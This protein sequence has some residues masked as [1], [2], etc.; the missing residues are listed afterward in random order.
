[1]NPYLLECYAGHLGPGQ[2]RALRVRAL[3]RD[4][5]RPHGQVAGLLRA[6]FGAGLWDPSD[7]DLAGQALAEAAATRL[8]ERGQWS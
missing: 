2:A 3:R 4:E 7:D 8:G 6:E 5:A 1:M